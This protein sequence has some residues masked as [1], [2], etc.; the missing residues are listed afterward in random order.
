M[1]PPTPTVAEVE[2]CQA[3]AGVIGAAVLS[4]EALQL[5]IGANGLL[6][7][8]VFAS[9]PPPLP[10][11][12][13]QAGVHLRVRWEGRFHASRDTWHEQQRA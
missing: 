10:Q 9:Q 3:I 5:L 12:A 7:G 1:T 11:A 2:E 8:G 13:V 6:D 4:G